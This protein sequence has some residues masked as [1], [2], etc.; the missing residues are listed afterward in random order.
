VISQAQVVD[1]ERRRARPTAIATMAAVALVV[2][3]AIVLGSVSG[4]DEAELLRSVHRH[5]SAV[6]ASSLLQALGFLLLLPGL[7]YLF[8]AALARSDQMRRQLIGVVI[9]APLFLAGYAVANGFASR[10][11]ASDFVAGKAD[12]QI[13]RQEAA[14]EC[15]SERKD[16]GADSFRRDFG[17]GSAASAFG[18]CVKSKLADDAAQA[19]VDNASLQPLAVGLGIGGRIGL[20]A[21]LVYTCLYGM[22]TGLLTRFWGSL[23]MALGVISFLV[24]QFTLVWFIYLGLLIAGWVPGG[25][26]PA[27]AAGEA[28][29]W[30]SPGEDASGAPDDS[31]PGSGRPVAED[32]SEGEE[33][34]SNPSRRP[35]ERRKRKQRR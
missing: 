14:R 12:P 4:D 9:A 19:A 34:A 35:G 10:D 31:V 24:L 18:D 20:A 15:R 26:P 8:T 1:H 29:P 13:T 6:V 25:R 30:P 32:P 16:K 5:E 11:A 3:S 17:G 28:I 27:W 21:G 22:R 2:A 33:P 23:G 7:L